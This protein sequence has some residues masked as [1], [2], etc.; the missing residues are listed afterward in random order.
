MD[1]KLIPLLED[2][3]RLLILGL[4]ANGV[5]SKD[6]AEVLHVDKSVISK[7][8]SSRIVKKK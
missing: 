1:N 2:I 8:I 4:I 6:V 3:K 7:I 5:L